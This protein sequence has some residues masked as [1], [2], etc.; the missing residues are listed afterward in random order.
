MNR[1]DFLAA[2]MMFPLAINSSQLFAA[3][4]TDIKTLVIFLRG[5]Y[6]ACNFLVPYTSDDYY[7]LR[8]R[9]AIAQPGSE[10][11]AALKLD[12]HWA[13]HPVFEETLIPLWNQKQISFIPFAGTEDLSRSHFETQDLMESGQPANGSRSR[14]SG[15]MNRL[16]G[17]L[18]AKAEPVSFTSN[19]PLIMQGPTRVPLIGLKSSGK[20][21]YKDNQIDLLEELYKGSHQ[22]EAVAE[23]IANHKMMLAEFE[24]E[25]QEASRNAINAKG[26]DLQVKRM[27]TLMKDK[28]SL[29][30]LDIGNWDT[31]YSQGGATGMLANQFKSL[32]SGLKTFA[33]EMGP[34][35][36]KTVVYVMSEFGRTFRENGSGGTDHGHGSVHWLLGGAIN[37]G[38]ILGEQTDVTVAALNQERDYKVLNNSRDVLGGLFKQIYGLN[39]GQVQKIF[40]SSKATSIHMV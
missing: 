34:Q 18:G 11:G 3:Q 19:N 27:A 40:P 16:A 39:N 5:A 2:G 10:E 13:M 15:F 1:R 30:F 31:H 23:G 22:A 28:Y 21:V 36:D 37:G 4:G 20:S 9:I 25:K 33:E 7:E 26:F 32:G 6:D 29:G 14:G 24:K 8:P 35:W 38:K 17:V 12:N